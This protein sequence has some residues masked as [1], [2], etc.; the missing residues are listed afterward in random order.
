MKRMIS[1]VL[2]LFI[3]LPLTA[4]GPA[5]SGGGLG[6]GSHRIE[7]TAVQAQEPWYLPIGEVGTY[8]EDIITGEI[9]S[10]CKLGDI[11]A[12]TLPYWTG[13]ILENKIFYNFHP[14]ERWGECTPGGRYWTEDQVRFQ[15]EQGF[16]CVRALYSFSYLSS[17][18][19]VWSINMAELEQLDELL[20]WCMKYDMHLMLSVTGLPGMSA[21][22]DWWE[23]ENIIF[24]DA[25]FTDPQMQEIFAA[26]W[27]MLSRRYAA[28]PSGALSFE[29][30]A[31]G[32]CTVP[33]GE[34]NA[35]GPDME[36]F[37]N[38][39]A[40]IA[41]SIWADRADRI[42]IVNDNDKNVP[43]QLAAIGC[44]LSLHTHVY[45]V[46]ESYF[47]EPQGLEDVDYRWPMEYLPRYFLDSRNG[48]LTLRAESVFHEGSLTLYGLDT[49][50]EAPPVITCDGAS[51]DVTETFNAQGTAIWTAE[52]PE[53]TKEVVFAPAGDRFHIEVFMVELKQAGRE[54]V[55]L[56]SYRSGFVEGEE[57]P[58][59]LI[60]DD[61][62]T[63]NLSGQV[64]DG[65]YIYKNHLQKFTDCAEQYGVGFLLTEVGTDTSVLSREEYLAYH[66]MWLDMLKSRHVSWMYNCDHNIFAPRDIMYLNGENNPIPF[67]RLSQWEDGPYWINDDVMDLLKAYQ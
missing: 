11:S 42:V 58:A 23:Q 34:P 13:L 24:S 39:L 6:R 4:C 27:K 31:E 56:C 32:S 8:N 46:G 63:Q 16:N 47:G 41:Q 57:F 15:A 38:T 43:E 48:V 35:G 30:E 52:V 59:I 40:P 49:Y 21:G 10:A 45:A 33:E 36:R 7:A 19:D 18:D 60:K 1:A 37:Y 26:Y 3:L 55:Q 22:A 20:S 12:D 64:L 25:L 65:D 44:C 66:E 50:T 2:M 14:D 9:V 29:L 54:K 67:E 51:M 28:I 53:G 62:T 17:P 5:V 61:G